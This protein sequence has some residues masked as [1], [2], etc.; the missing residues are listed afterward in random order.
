MNKITTVIKMAVLLLL[1]FAIILSVTSCTKREQTY[2]EIG[3]T[4]PKGF[5]KLSAPDDFDLAFENGD[6]VIGIRRLSFSAVLEEGLLTTHTPERLAEIY[7]ERL[8]VSGA[9]TVFL[10]GDVP[11][12]IYTLYADGGT[13]AYMPTFYRTSYAYFIITFICKNSI[14]EGTRVKFFGVCD[15]VY[16]LPEYV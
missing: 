15:S 7:R 14:D 4:L 1:V 12:F 10:H 9:S 8:N 2:C 11:Y 13:Y 16:I 5:V 6:E 3:F